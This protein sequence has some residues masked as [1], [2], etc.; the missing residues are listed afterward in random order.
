M[1]I[2]LRRYPTTREERGLGCGQCSLSVFLSV[3]AFA[4]ST[5]FRLKKTGPLGQATDSWPQRQ[6]GGQEYRIQNKMLAFGP[7]ERH[8]MRRR[9]VVLTF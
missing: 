4:M 5:L 9:A 2:G 6:N 8:K 7:A 3:R 1:R